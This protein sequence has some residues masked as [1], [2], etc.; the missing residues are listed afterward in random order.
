MVEQTGLTHVQIKTWFANARRRRQQNEKWEKK[1][2]GIAESVEGPKAA[3]VVGRRECSRAKSSALHQGGGGKDGSGT[4]GRLQLEEGQFHQTAVYCVASPSP[5]ASP[6]LSQTSPTIQALASPMAA[7]QFFHTSS[8]LL[9]PQ[10]TTVRPPTSSALQSLITMT[11]NPG[12]QSE[13]IEYTETR[14]PSLRC[15]AKVRPASAAR[16]KSHSLPHKEVR[17]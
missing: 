10:A 2:V 15:G 7:Q 14:H 11:N 12:A 17:V 16:E 13:T 9:Y 4:T 5:L 3:K 1:M 8:P 6:T